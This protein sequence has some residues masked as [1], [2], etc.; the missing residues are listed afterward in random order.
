MRNKMPKHTAAVSGAGLR[1]PFS[2]CCGLCCRCHSSRP[3]SCFKKLQDCIL[4]AVLAGLHAVCGHCQCSSW[5]DDIVA[6]CYAVPGAVAG[7]DAAMLLGAA[8]AR[9][10]LEN[11]KVDSLSTE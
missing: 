3:R 4:P 10:M 7:G 5:V 8:A 11:I 1:I 2:R 9:V 6:A